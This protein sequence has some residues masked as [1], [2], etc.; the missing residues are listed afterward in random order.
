[1]LGF[2]SHWKGISISDEG[3]CPPHL[4]KNFIGVKFP[5][6]TMIFLTSYN[7]IF[8]NNKTKMFLEKPAKI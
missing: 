5:Y 4:V 8:L 7:N 3:K 6:I 1:M 2:I